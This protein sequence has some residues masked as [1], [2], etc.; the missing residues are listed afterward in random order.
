M[1]LTVEDG[2]GL[3]DAD[4]YLSVAAADTYHTA[5]GNTAWTSIAAS[6]ATTKEQYLRKATDYID[7]T[8]FGKWPG[9]RLV[10]TQSLSWPR[11]GVEIDSIDYDTLDAPA[12]MPQYLLDATAEVA[13][14][15][16]QGIDPEPALDHGG[17]IKAIT[18]VVGPLS[19]RI[20][21]ADDAP[22]NTIYQRI[23]KLIRPLLGLAGG[24]IMSTVVRG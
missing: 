21:Y 18:N 11:S 16:A 4:S 3:A 10:T 17:R 15:Y 24:K 8:W 2:T 20:A 12:N 22:A 14:L 6:P 1:A 23:D 9:L 7:N 19:Q 5:R 13:L